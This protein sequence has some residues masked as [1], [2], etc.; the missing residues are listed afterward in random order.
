MFLTGHDLIRRV[1]IKNLFMDW[2]PRRRLTCLFRIDRSPLSNQ[3]ALN[4][5]IL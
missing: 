5:S 3:R 1:R 2:L 4:K